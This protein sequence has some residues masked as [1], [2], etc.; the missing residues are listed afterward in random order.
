MNLFFHYVSR[1][2][3]TRAMTVSRAELRAHLEGRE[4]GRLLDYVG[5][6]PRGITVSFDDAH[7][8]MIEHAL[9]VL[10]E[11]GVTATLFVPT[12]YV[13][14][15]D[16]F[17]SWDQL[18]RLRDEGWTIGSHTHTHPRLRFREYS[19][20]EAAYAAR[21]LD[22][23]ERSR[24]LLYRE[25]GET[26]RLFAYPYGEAFG[27]ELVRKVG[28]EAAFTVSDAPWD[29][30][31]YAIPRC[32][33][34]IPET[35]PPAPETPPP[36]EGG[37]GSG[38]G[39]PNA[40]NVL[41]AATIPPG[42]LPFT[43]VV[44]ACDRVHILSNVVTRLASLS[45]PKDHYEVIVVDDGSH[46]DL[47][48]IFSEMPD[49]VRLVRQ[50]DAT[51]RAGQARQRGADE[52]RFDHLAFLDAD[53]AVGADFLWHLDWA[54]R[55]T[56]DAVVLGYL[57][58]YNLHDLGHVH[59][60]SWRDEGV[61][62]P[63]RS[64]EP[65]LRSCLDQLDW[66]EN[67]WPLTYTGNLSLPKT[68]LD[69]V[70]GFAREFEGWGLEDVDL[71]I[72]LFRAGARFAF[73]RFAMGWHLVDPNENHSRNP[74]RRE[75]PRR[76]DF[77]G[78]LTNLALLAERHPEPDVQAYVE[79][80]RADIEETI[81]E[82]STVGIEMGGAASVRGKYH[83][84]LHSVFPGG[85]PKHELLDR[86]AYAK[87]VGA[88][89]IYLLGGEPTEHPAFFDLL[90]AAREVVSWISMQTLVYPF[91]GTDLAKRSRDAGLRGAVAMI[92]RFDRTM[93]EGLDALGKELELSVHL[94][95]TPESDEHETRREIERRGLSIVETTR[96]D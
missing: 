43:V 86:V 28:Y 33:P 83:R 66:L 60:P 56:P 20:D 51:F 89:T 46:E 54:H 18:R 65:T 59:T 81:G 53:V 22:E 8:S 76:E 70:G 72:R 23:L 15:S 79:R 10:R 35:P 42:P 2:R 62:I 67:P 78:Y 26:P 63:D 90:R 73:S 52:A 7:V 11:L 96:I 38:G 14:T 1:E 85:I 4:V 80:S 17:L 64:R 84:R 9:P 45:Y 40:P 31:R 82:P 12:A 95:V 58:G 50:G 68:L 34:P 21:V 37:R 48:P 49:H 32:D 74:F 25:L 5:G 93:H 27:K 75:R 55:H 41:L 61:I 44:P 77:A 88:K 30:D 3:P 13:E 16:E 87:K 6:A 39:G 94:V 57:S 92:E 71:G 19:E 91:A 36:A 69:R 47:S 24:D 29:G